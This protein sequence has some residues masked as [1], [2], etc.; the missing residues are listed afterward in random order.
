[1]SDDT[2]LTLLWFLPLAGSA[3]VLFIPSRT[4]QSIK[5]F[6]LTVTLLTLL[7]TL[8]AYGKYVSP[9]SRAFA[10]LSDRVVLNPVAVSDAGEAGSIEGDLVVRREWI[11]YFNIQYYLGIDGISLSLILLTGLVSVL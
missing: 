1:M 10:P 6:S 5:V 9:G 7:L 11:P 4:G 2:L 3:A 8:V